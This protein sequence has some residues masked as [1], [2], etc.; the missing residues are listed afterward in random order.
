MS[1]DIEQLQLNYGVD[2]R[3]TV[4]LLTRQLVLHHRAPEALPDD[5][6]SVQRAF[7]EP[8]EFPG[9]EQTILP[10]DRLVIV[11][12]VD[13]PWADRIFAELWRRLSS[14]GFS[15]ENVILVQP[16]IWK[17]AEGVDPR[18]RL[19]EEIK[20]RFTLERHDPTGPESCAYLASTA[21]GERIY[22][23]RLLT[24]ADVVLTIGPVEFD[25]VLGVR[26]TAS[27]LYPGLSDVDALRRAQGQ[28]HEELGPFD[29]RPFRQLVDEIGWL[30]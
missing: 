27:S 29:V 9:L 13:T 22:L 8:V 14:V 10:D 28:G 1:E 11:I 4:D 12:D 25:P 18:A 30:L 21:G 15:P 20:E 16:A 26:G 5:E 2:G 23:S 17:K 19:P 24:D 7:D 6:A 3:F